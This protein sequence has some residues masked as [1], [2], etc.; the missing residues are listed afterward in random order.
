MPVSLASFSFHKDNRC[1]GLG[2]T[3]HIEYD[4]V[5]TIISA[6]TPLLDK[7]TFTGLEV[8]TQ[9]YFVG[10]D[11][12]GVLLVTSVSQM[13]HCFLSFQV[14]EQESGAVWLSLLTRCSLSW[15]VV[16]KGVCL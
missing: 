4:C 14:A 7:V 2:L 5:L 13:K 9:A 16:C 12:G 6:V 3:H 8:R 11:G 10:R 15:S 1:N